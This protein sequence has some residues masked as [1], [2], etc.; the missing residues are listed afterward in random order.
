MRLHPSALAILS[1]LVL[2]SHGRARNTVGD[3]TVNPS[4]PSDRA[5]ATNETVDF[6]YGLCHE[7]Y[8]VPYVGARA[9]GAMI[10][11]ATFGEDRSTLLHHVIC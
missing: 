3:L 7:N 11:N 9:G 1:T 4:R 10:L 8:R 2:A 5:R 6:P